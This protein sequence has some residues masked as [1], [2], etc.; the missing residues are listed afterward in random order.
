MHSGH[1]TWNLLT[2]AILL[3]ELDNTWSHTGIV[4]CDWSES[5][6]EAGPYLRFLFQCEDTALERWLELRVFTT[7]WTVEVEASSEWTLIE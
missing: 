1:L 3:N 7:T 6:D 5:R 4:R 2:A